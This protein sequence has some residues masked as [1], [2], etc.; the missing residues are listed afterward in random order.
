M[1]KANIQ[2][3]RFMVSG[4][5]AVMTDMGTYFLFLH[6]LSHSPAKTIS[7][8][9]GTIVAFLLNKFWTFEKPAISMKEIV[10]FG[11]LY[12]FTLGANVGAN[13]TFLWLLVGQ[14]FI[15]FLAATCVS[16]TLNF[17]GQKHWVFK[18]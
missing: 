9:L 14:V 4:I 5:S 15:A 12:L 1:T 10:K 7:F 17:L 16:A 18:S 6:I 2:L 8:I 11:L 3:V 13:K